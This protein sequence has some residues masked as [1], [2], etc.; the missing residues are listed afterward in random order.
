MRCLEILQGEN[1]LPFF[2]RHR[3]KEVS[4]KKVYDRYAPGSYT[5]LNESIE[6]L[7]GD[8]SCM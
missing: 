1:L 5:R 4:L 6:M 2:L 3:L 7:Y 8:P